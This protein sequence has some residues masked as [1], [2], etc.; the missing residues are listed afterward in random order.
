MIAFLIFL[1]AIKTSYAAFL[2]IVPASAGRIVGGFTIDITKVPYQVSIQTTDGDHYCGGT[3]IRDN[4]VLTAGHCVKF[5]SN[6]KD[7]RVYLGSTDR[8]QGGIAIQAQKLKYHEDFEGFPA[9][10]MKNDIALIRLSESAPLSENISVIAVATHDPPAGSIALATGWGKL[11]EADY[12]FEIPT[13]LQGVYLEMI[14]IATCRAAY[15]ADLVQD[16]NICA[17][18]TGKDACQGDSGGPIVVDDILV[19]IVSWGIGCAEKGN[20]GVYTSTASFNDWIVKTIP[21]L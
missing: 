16:H 10:A 7:V 17:Y 9:R 4:I 13:E 3:L 5:S 20:P 18:S 15:G 8:T 6:P 21:T 14:S 1:I 2:G 12:D 11:N 19:G